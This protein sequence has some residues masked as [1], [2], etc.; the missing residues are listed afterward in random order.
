[1]LFNGFQCL[2]LENPLVEEETRRS[3]MQNGRIFI[4]VGLLT[5][6]L[7]TKGLERWYSVRRYVKLRSDRTSKLKHW[8]KLK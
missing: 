4:C 6:G 2:S 8:E 3:R 7:Q 5:R 1:M